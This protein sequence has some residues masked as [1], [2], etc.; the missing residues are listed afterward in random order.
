MAH[1]GRR[2]TRNGRIQGSSHGRQ[3]SGNQV[4]STLVPSLFASAAL[5]SRGDSIGM[6]RDHTCCYR[7]WYSD[8]EIKG[9]NH[10]YV[11][12]CPR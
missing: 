9:Q 11:K 7:Y 1:K 2:L 8:S 3:V 10:Q 4:I 6:G 12:G 5:A